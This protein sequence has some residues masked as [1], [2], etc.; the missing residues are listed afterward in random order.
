MDKNNKSDIAVNLL[1]V[2]KSPN[3]AERI[4]SCLRNAGI[5]V[6]INRADDETEFVET[7]KN[8]D[9]DMIMYS[10]DASELDFS[11]AMQLYEQIELELPVIV[12]SKNES[13]P[14]FSAYIEDGAKDVLYSGN[15]PHLQFAV[16]RELEV[17]HLK[18]DFK[19]LRNKLKESED[20]CSALIESSRDAIAYVH[21]GMHMYANQVYLEMFGYVDNEDIE[22]MP[23]LDMISPPQLKEFKKFLRNLGKEENRYSKLESGCVGAD[24]NTFDAILE[25]S[26]ATYDG[27]PCTQIL[28]R[29]QSHSKELQQRLLELSNL[30]SET[31]LHNR[32][33]LTQLLEDPDGNAEYKSV[34]YI[35]V[36]NFQELRTSA[37]MA[38]TD[39]VI[40]DYAD[41][42]T[43][44]T[45]DRDLNVRYSDHVFIIL[46][47][48][49][50]TIEAEAL[51]GAFCTAA[52]THLFESVVQYEAPVSRVGI[53][54]R[55]PSKLQQD[56][57]HLGF[58]AS[59]IAEKNETC[60]ATFDP[61]LAAPSAASDDGKSDIVKLVEYALE[62]DHFRL[63]FQPI[64]SLQG[65][66]RENYA[67]LLRLLDNNNEEIKPADFFP[68]A[69]LAGL[70]GKID[71]WVIN[72]A[73]KELAEQRSQGRKINFF[74]SLSAASVEN[75][76]LPL[77][78]CDVLRDAKIKGAWLVFQLA[79]NVVRQNLQM[80]KKLIEGLNKIKVQ[81]AIDQFGLTPKSESLLKNLPFDYMKLHPSFMQNLAS[82]QENQDKM[83]SL[84]EIA[85]SY[86]I[87]TVAT[88]VED[89]NSLAILWT[90][91]VNYIQG[92]FLQEP[93][94][95]ISYDFNAD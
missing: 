77:W 24:G 58:Q 80:A 49:A 12:L 51:A 56:L 6:H 61:T 71:R 68:Q 13:L 23:I 40:K 92:Y 18:Q 4:A 70:M 7:L 15:S 63:V 19:S 32:Q 11:R 46:S 75:E 31:G 27:E 38:A 57:I 22:G 66:S 89:A 94:D 53:A 81:F 73:V 44:V 64:V 85:H 82:N 47:R 1:V 55:D 50:D 62:H 3:E 5:G 65:D 67:V 43:D 54:Y 83:N 17:H 9:I 48:R 74:L 25:F 95:S 78:V 60:F 69:E 8:T 84:N 33:F 90:V 42:I 52:E 39:A 34:L 28:I 45:D 35:T 29:D 20:R 14:N 2:D 36:T 91:G 87:K 16:A 86:N 59:E 41:L 79:D 76:D 88:G 93:S 72:N 21:E 10:E 37:G 30:D 26:P